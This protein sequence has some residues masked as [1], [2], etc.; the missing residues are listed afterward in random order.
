MHVSCMQT[1]HLHRAHLGHN[2][3]ANKQDASFV[4]ELFLIKDVGVLPQHGSRSVLT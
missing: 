3:V 2:L 1:D 4:L